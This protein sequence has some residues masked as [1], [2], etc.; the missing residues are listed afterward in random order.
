MLS[1]NGLILVVPEKLYAGEAEFILI[2]LKRAEMDYG[3]TS[4]YT[5]QRKNP[6]DSISFYNRALSKSKLKD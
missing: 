3:A 1:T 4:D 6:N 2:A 5:K